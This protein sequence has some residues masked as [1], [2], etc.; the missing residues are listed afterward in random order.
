MLKKNSCKC[1]FVNLMRAK[2]MLCV[3]KFKIVFLVLTILGAKFP[4][5]LFWESC[6]ATQV[7]KFNFNAKSGGASINQ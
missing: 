3:P 7:A 2:L 4:R 5:P 6:L 1:I